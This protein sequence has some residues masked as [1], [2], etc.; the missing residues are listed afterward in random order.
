M[1]QARHRKKLLSVGPRT[2]GTGFRYFDRPPEQAPTQEQLAAK[3]IRQEEQQILDQQKQYRQETVTAIC[4]GAERMLSK[5]KQQID[6][7]AI[8]LRNFAGWTT[9][10][11]CSLPVDPD[12]AQ[13]YSMQ[14][15]K[16]RLREPELT[17]EMMDTIVR[18]I[19][20]ADD[21]R[22][23]VAEILDIVRSSAEQSINGVK[24]DKQLF[25]DTLLKRQK[26]E[27][28]HHDWVSYGLGFVH[29]LMT[30]SLQV[31]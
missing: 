1:G 16:H 25:L 29:E 10:M 7:N 6:Q 9:D 19:F 11:V 27:K 3:A 31:V 24:F 26:R 17:L 4:G 2:T 13:V 18:K 20:H 28:S 30:R 22:D 23:V 5:W 12:A 21:N 14:F 15:S 8:R